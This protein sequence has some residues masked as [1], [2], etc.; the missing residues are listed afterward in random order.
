MEQLAN[1]GHILI[2]PF[3]I[4]NGL[5]IYRIATRESADLKAILREADAEVKVYAE[6]LKDNI[7]ENIDVIQTPTS[8]TKKAVVEILNSVDEQVDIL[9]TEHGK[10]LDK[11]IELPMPT[12][13][14]TL[15]GIGMGIMAII[16]IYSLLK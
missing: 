3:L 6:T 10:V 7:K 2:M 4:I 15:I 8:L 16:E 14:M 1:I 13:A 12:V 9:L 11:F 5:L